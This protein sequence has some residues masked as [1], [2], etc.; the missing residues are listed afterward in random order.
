MKT[1]LG[2]KAFET[3]ALRLWNSLNEDIQQT[4]SGAENI[5]VSN[6]IHWFYVGLIFILSWQIFKLFLNLYSYF[7]VFLLCLLFGK[8]FVMLFWEVLL[9]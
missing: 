5:L 9:K 6:F 1:K 4:E 3:R 7:D 8:H 2:D